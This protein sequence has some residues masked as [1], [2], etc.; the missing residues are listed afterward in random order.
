MREGLLRVSKLIWI[1]LPGGN[2]NIRKSFPLLE[3]GEGAFIGEEILYEDKGTYSYTVTVESQ[4][5]RLFVFER[6]S[7]VRDYSTVTV[8]SFLHATHQEKRMNR[9]KHVER[10]ERN[11]KHYFI[12]GGSVGREANALDEC[13]QDVAGN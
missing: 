4:T 12:N 11:C 3:V 7:N 1:P 10:I 13:K 2:G 9:L 5:A 6:N 8:T